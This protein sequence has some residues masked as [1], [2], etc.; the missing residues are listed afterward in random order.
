MTRTRRN[1]V[2]VAAVA[3]LAAAATGCLPAAGATTTGTSTSTATSSQGSRSSSCPAAFP[4]PVPAAPADPTAALAE[5]PVREED[6]GAHYDR[7]DWL[8]RWESQGHG[9]TTR[10]VVLARD[11]CTSGG[12]VSPYDGV[13]ITVSSRVDIDHVVPLGEAAR[14][15]TRWW[16]TSQRHAFANYTANLRSVSAHANRSKGDDDPARWRPG[17]R[18]VWCAYA[19]QYIDVKAHFALTV[20]PAEQAALRSMLSTC[21]R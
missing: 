13:Q 18:A 10:T 17:Q 16:S 2:V 19:T 1:A 7:H 5:L 15:G 8:P 11:R 14:S 20:D 12:W 21:H 3:T 9:R 6:S 4:T